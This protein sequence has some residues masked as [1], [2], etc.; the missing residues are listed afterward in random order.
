MIQ[1]I[2]ALLFGDNLPPADKELPDHAQR[3][4]P[5]APNGGTYIV[6]M[7]SRRLTSPDGTPLEDFNTSIDMYHESIRQTLARAGYRVPQKQWL[8]TIDQVTANVKVALPL[9]ND[10]A[11]AALLAALNNDA[12][13]TMSYSIIAPPGRP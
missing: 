3:Q 10:E 9:A 5:A 1:H 13:N 7:T 8:T 11:A 12:S 4:G 2:R 6:S